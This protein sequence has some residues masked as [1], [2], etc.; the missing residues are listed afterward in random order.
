MYSPSRWLPARSS[1]LWTYHGNPD[2][3]SGNPIGHSSRGV[4]L[5]RSAMA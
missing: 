4:A 2:P 1:I 3:K 5:A